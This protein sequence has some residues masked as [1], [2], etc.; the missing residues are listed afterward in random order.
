MSLQAAV[1]ALPGR[2]SEAIKNLFA[3][4]DEKLT[5]LTQAVEALTRERDALQGKLTQAEADLGT[6]RQTISTLQT[7][8][9]AKAEKIAALEADQKTVAQ[10][11]AE[12]VAA[13]GIPAA[14]VPPLES[15][16]TVSKEAELEAVRQQI[17][18]EK[19]PEKRY[20]LS[21][22]ARELRGHGDL[23]PKR[24]GA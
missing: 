8:A 13:Q 22:K 17:A 20:A 2:I 16:S 4:T 19:D 5:K 18:A 24:H 6:A 3:T 12:L 23:F 11:A 9:Q 1:E 14:K 10:A 21:L 7:E 15:S